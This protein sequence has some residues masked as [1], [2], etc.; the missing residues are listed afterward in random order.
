VVV[1]L[2]DDLLLREERRAP[3]L[4]PLVKAGDGLNY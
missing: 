4:L 1:D 2:S 3:Q